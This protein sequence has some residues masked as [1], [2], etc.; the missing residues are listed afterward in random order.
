MRGGECQREERETEH[1]LFLPAATFSHEQRTHPG[2]LLR[3]SWNG[4]A[5]C[6]VGFWF[7]LVFFWLSVRAIY[8]TC[9]SHR[10]GGS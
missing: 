6:L 9:K 7:F 10:D 4:P 1:F 5:F 2:W 3:R 8:K